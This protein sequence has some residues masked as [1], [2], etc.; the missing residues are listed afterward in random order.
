VTSLKKGFRSSGSIKVGDVVT[1]I[2]GT[3]VEHLP[4]EAIAALCDGESFE[5]VV[6]RANYGGGNDESSP[7]RSAV[8]GLDDDGE[9]DLDV[10]GK[11]DGTGIVD[12]TDDDYTDDDSDEDRSIGQPE[13][14][15]AKGGGSAPAEK[16]FKAAANSV[17]FGVRMQDQADLNS[18]AG[19][20]LQGLEAAKPDRDLTAAVAQQSNE[21]LDAGGAAATA[22]EGKAGGKGDE[23]L[24]SSSSSEGEEDETYDI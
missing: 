18:F 20:F 8:P 9:V 4:H 6:E 7:Y 12:S 13:S 14:N 22:R 15:G 16:S 10:A 19:D 21:D 2:N 23:F 1:S 3:G 17:V 24:A 5:C 11:I